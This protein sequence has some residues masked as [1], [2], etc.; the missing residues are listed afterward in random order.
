MV[1]HSESPLDIWGSSKTEQLSMR[2]DSNSISQLVRFIQMLGCQNHTPVFFDFPN[3]FPNFLSG[4]WVQSWSGLIQ[5]N[6][7][8][9]AQESQSHRQSALHSSTQLLRTLWSTFRSV[10]INV[11][12]GFVNSLIPSMLVKTPE[13]THELQVLFHC[14]FFHY[15]IELLAEAETGSHVVNI[16]VNVVTKDYSQWFLLLAVPLDGG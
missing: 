1:P 5:H 16:E 14:Q 6:Q 15:H 2:H 11:L 10:K 12:K 4:H 13:S 8:R 3:D 9:V 7:I